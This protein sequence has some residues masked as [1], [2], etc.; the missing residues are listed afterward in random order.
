MERLGKNATVAEVKERDAQGLITRNLKN[1]PL[2]DTVTV[3]DGGYTVVRFIANNPG[4]IKSHILLIKPAILLF[5]FLSRIFLPFQ[6]FQFFMFLISRLMFIF[7]SKVSLRSLLLRNT[8]RETVSEFLLALK[9]I[10]S[11]L[12]DI[13]YMN[14][15]KRP[16]TLN[17]FYLLLLALLI[18]VDI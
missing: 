6:F 16:I 18:F 14:I 11:R 9:I 13:K 17:I 8:Q 12:S 5:F 15:S 10:F 3:P 1:P 7:L 2:K 4:K